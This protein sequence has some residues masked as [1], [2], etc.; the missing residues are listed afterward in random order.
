MQ[1]RTIV[2]GVRA[3]RDIRPDELRAL[4][5]S[6]DASD[7]FAAAR[8]VAQRAFGRDIYLRG[9]IEF[10]N[11]C[12]NDCY[13][14]GIRSGN[15]RAERY[16]LSNEQILSCCET[17]YALGFR[18]FVLQGGEDPFFTDERIVGIVSAMRRVYP[19]CAITLSLGEKPRD[20][21]RRY[22]DAG[23]D[24]YLLRHETADEAHYARLHPPALSFAARRRCL[25]DLKDIGF[26]VGCGFMVGSPGQTLE[27]IFR[28]LQFIREL[29]PH[30]VGIGPFIPHA[31]TPF[32]GEAA[33]TLEDTLRLLSIVRLLL[34]NVL[35]PATTA[36]GTI[37]PT[38]REQGIR[39]GANV[40]MPNLSPAD[41]RGKYMLYDDKICTGDEAAECRACLERR[42]ASIGYRIVSG[43]GD[44]AD[45]RK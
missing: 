6:E 41:V 38:G 13:Y 44:H 10:T 17:G 5:T 15:A 7:L 21:Y 33:G 43:R 12:K 40:V 25:W 30:M 3:R 20:S 39:A 26:Q 4:L 11:W 16:R 42:I 31:D 29:S 24:R 45:M 18:T 27:A 34:P 23:A 19:D 22:F 36:L 1:Y 37:D 8:A 14:C 28:D 9:L 2:D 32:A 35:L